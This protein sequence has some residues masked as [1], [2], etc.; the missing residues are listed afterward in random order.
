M[1]RSIPRSP[2]RLWLAVLCGGLAASGCSL[3]IR[4]ATPPPTPG[5]S[6]VQAP[7]AGFRTGEAGSVP[8]RLEA[9]GADAKGWSALYRSTPAN[10][11]LGVIVAEPVLK[12]V[13]TQSGEFSRGCGRWLQLAVGG[14]GEMGKTP[15]W[16][17]VNRVGRELGKKDLRLSL[18]EAAQAAASLGATHVAVGE[19]GG[20]ASHC[21]VTYQLWQ[22]PERKQVGPP[23]TATGTYAD[24][25]QQLP[26]LAETLAVALAVPAPRVPAS[27]AVTPDDMQLLGRA[28]WD[29]SPLNNPADL[30]RLQTLARTVPLA[31]LLYLHTP[32]TLHAELAGTVD[33]LV[34][35]APENALVLGEIG[36]LAP[37]ELSRHRVAVQHAA[38]RFPESYPIADAE[39]CLQRSA[40]DGTAE[41]NAARRAVIC[42]RDNAEAWLS[43]GMS[44]SE[45]STRL[46]HGRTA[47]RIAPAEWARL[48]ALYVQTYQ[49][50]YTAVRLDPLYGKAWFRLAT[51]A[52]FAGDELTADAA[53]WK[54]EPLMK[55]DSELIWWGLQMYQ[56]KW[57]NQRANLTKVA[58]MAVDTRFTS[59]K[60]A[61]KIIRELNHAGYR[62]QALAITQRM[63]SDA[64]SELL[65]APNSG[66]AHNTL[67]HVLAS[68]SDL[69]GAT[70]EY[71]AA[72]RLMPEDALT[73]YDLA[74]LL[75]RRNMPGEA[76]PE[77]RQ[78]ARFA[79]REGNIHVQ[80]GW[81]LT[82]T[83]RL[84]EA[85]QESR[86]G[87]K[88]L[89]NSAEAHEGLGEV[90]SQQKHPDAA[91]PE[92][93]TALR[94]N[95]RF[96]SALLTLAGLMYARHHSAEAIAAAESA[97]RLAPRNGNARRYLGFLYVTAHQSSAAARELELALQ[98]NPDDANAHENLGEALADLGQ[99]EEARVH[100]K[101]VLELDHGGTAAEARRM[102][103]KYP[104]PR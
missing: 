55:G 48:N 2:H 67:A 49:A 82:Q 51:A 22:V 103:R 36:R 71:R 13:D 77:Y 100:W 27:A 101:R 73:H 35:L 7:S 45:A 98:M 28:S 20:T 9:P 5:A 87:V 89:P 60:Q 79:P 56:P 63:E 17:S 84:A 92:V 66:P 65:H 76:I 52:T 80:L 53:F 99:K 94:L 75:S 69:E 8:G 19:A 78:A 25:L 57:L 102:L 50:A 4:T 15:L 85:E 59:F 23:L 42:A 30:H 72:A 83:G 6:G 62:S 16:V 95:P 44:L 14:H 104:A 40:G 33:A 21:T 90:L 34:R 11:S 46:R 74:M 47:D 68:Q 70:A 3:R 58:Q 97:A 10:S 12:E 37:D 29:P 81:A 24:V 61:G 96:P 1:L 64:R 18:D 38:R 26:R 86:L 54:A 88:L 43:L 39:A 32:P 93:Q 31:G 41:R 91:L